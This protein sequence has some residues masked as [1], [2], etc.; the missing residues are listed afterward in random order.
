[1]P[2]E[3][4]GYERASGARALGFHLGQDF[5]NQ[6]LE[7]QDDETMRLIRTHFIEGNSQ[8]QTAALLNMDRNMVRKQLRML[9]LRLLRFMK[10]HGQIR[11]LDPDELLAVARRDG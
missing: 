2:F 7:E 10:S 11:S 6:S 4:D 8:Q 9:R 3:I 5:L 1:M